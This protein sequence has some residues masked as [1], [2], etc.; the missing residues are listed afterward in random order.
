MSYEGVQFVEFLR[1][2]L[3]FQRRQMIDPY[4]PNSYDLLITRVAQAGGA[5]VSLSSKIYLAISMRAAANI[6][7]RQ[8]KG[9]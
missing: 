4:R 8:V 5:K 3:D 2:A 7:P 6:K 1:P 9:H